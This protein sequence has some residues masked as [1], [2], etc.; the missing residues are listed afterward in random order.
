MGYFKSYI[1]QIL[2]GIK[3]RKTNKIG[4][5]VCFS[6]DTAIGIGCTVNDGTTFCTNVILGSKIKVGKGV[7]LSNI[8]ISTGSI[9][10]S[11]CLCIGNKK[12]IIKLGENVYIGISNCLDNSDNITIGNNVQI[13]GPSTAIYTHSGAYMAINGISLDELETTQ[14]RSTSP[15][16]I[17]DNVYIGC[18]CTVY[19]GVTIGHHSIIAPNSAVTKNVEPFTMVG[20]V[21]AKVI[22]SITLKD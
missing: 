11:F 1:K 2:L 7:F 16:I 6:K 21:P 8:E 20:G 14:Y 5:N 18:N 19:P 12:G 15:V 13:A 22:K 17:E 3:H 4:K 10:E 9:I